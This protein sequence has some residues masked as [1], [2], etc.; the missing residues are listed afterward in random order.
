MIQNTGTLPESDPT[1]PQAERHDPYGVLR[2]RNFLLYLIGRFVASLG[3]QMLTV[4]VGWELYQRTHSALHLGLVGLSQMVPM[5]FFTLPAG[6]AADNFS[7]KRII[8]LTTFVVACASIGLTL[9]SALEAHVVWIYVCLFAAG[10]A[11][12]FLWPASSAF[13]PH[14]V[15]RKEFSKAVTWSSGSFHLSSVAGPAAGGLVI[16]ATGHAATVYAINAAAGLIC[17]LLISFVHWHYSIAVREK[18]TAAS[19]IAGFDFVFKNRIILGTITLDMFAVLLGG[20]TTLLPVYAK[21]ILGTGP[22][23]L[24]FLQAALPMGSLLCALILAHRPPLQK[25]GRAL[26]WAVVAFGAATI[27]FGLSRWFWLSFL[28]LF[29]CGS[30]DNISVVVRHTLVQL[31]TPDEKR[32]RVSAVNSLFIGTSNE[33]GGFESGFVAH[34]T[35]PVFSVVSGGIGTILVVIIVAWIWPEIRKYGRLDA[36]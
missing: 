10:T 20:A 31:L 27:V 35:S 28:M 25:A 4:A 18:M 34:L 22:A 1:P 24:G 2:N 33:L 14:L 12:T 30:V 6:H 19:L 29:V 5:I 3:Q 7:R 13:L 36:G 8:L 9:I 21:D 11:R 26:L 17:L 16:A 32:G 23:A 15:S